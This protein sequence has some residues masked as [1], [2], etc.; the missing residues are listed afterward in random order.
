MKAWLFAHQGSS[1][2][3]VGQA[4]AQVAGVSDFAQRYP[5]ELQALRAR[6]DAVASAGINSTPSC[7]IN[8]VPAVDEHGRLLSPA[9]MERAIQLELHR[10]R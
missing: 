6:V 9:Q 5:S 2:D 1:P 8:G 3:D 7:Y 4:A 10:P